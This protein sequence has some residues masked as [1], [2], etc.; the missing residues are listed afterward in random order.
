MVCAGG[1]M[2][3]SLLRDDHTW[4]IE[5]DRRN[6]VSFSVWS[7]PFHGTVRAVLFASC[8]RSFPVDLQ[9][10]PSTYSSLLESSSCADGF[11]QASRACIKGLNEKPINSIYSSRADVHREN[12]RTTSLSHNF[13]DGFSQ[14]PQVFD[15]GNACG[16]K[17]VYLIL[18]LSLPT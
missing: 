7:Q 18:R 5:H 17:G 9:F 10:Y 12:F 3:H 16:L 1:L 15:D 8:S 4:H 11:M 13:K 2:H 6:T 14:P